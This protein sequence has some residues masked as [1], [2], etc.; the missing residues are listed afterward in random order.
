MGT[1]NESISDFITRVQSSSATPNVS[2]RG[3]VVRAPGCCS[4][5]YGTVA[6]VAG[7]RYPIYATFN[8]GGGGDYMWTK[9]MLPG[10]SSYVTGVRGEVSNGL[11]YYYNS[12]FGSSSSRAGIYLSGN[13]TLTANSTM[14]SSNATVSITGTLTSD[15]TRNLTVDTSTFTVGNVSS[16]GSVSISASSLTAGNFS[17]VNTL[18]L[19]ATTINA[20]TY[21][22]NQ[23]ITFNNSGAQTVSNT[24]SGNGK[25]I[26]TGTGV[27]TVTGNN[28]FLG[29]VDIND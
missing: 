26:K 25:L 14:T 20:G 11:G 10:Q 19:N 24:I 3:L 12:G 13:T 28:S 23:S 6:L 21:D 4:T 22:V 5:V 15:S 8:E 9:F 18:A 27:L 1:A 16:M 7:N 17:S 2:E 29:G